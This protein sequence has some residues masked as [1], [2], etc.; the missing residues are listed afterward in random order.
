M[1]LLLYIGLFNLS[2]NSGVPQLN[3]KHLYPHLFP[4]P[5]FHE[6]QGI[7][8]VISSSDERIASEEDKM[9]ALNDLKQTLMSVLLSGEL[10]VPR[11][12]ET[13]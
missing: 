6:Q 11:N 5:S 13:V 3:N 1:Y 12:T 8:K 10:R 2:D 4:I 9:F 7:A